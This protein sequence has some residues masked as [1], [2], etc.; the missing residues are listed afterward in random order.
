MATASFK[1]DQGKLWL[2]QQMY[3]I[4]DINYPGQK[5]KVFCAE[6]KATKIAMKQLSTISS[7]QNQ[8]SS[9]R[10]NGP[11]GYIVG[12]N[13]KADGVTGFTLLSVMAKERLF[14]NKSCLSVSF[15]PYTNGFLWGTAT[16]L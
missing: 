14:K 5:Q 4:Y 12:P 15:G 2:D 13:F 11:L 9:C 10:K 8:C 16:F 6:C 3:V 7:I 1:I